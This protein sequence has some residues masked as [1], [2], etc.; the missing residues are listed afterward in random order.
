MLRN[1][2]RHA[3]FIATDPKDFFDT[4][5]N[6]L[7]MAMLGLCNNRPNGLGGSPI[8]DS[9]SRRYSNLKLIKVYALGVI[10]NV[11]T[12]QIIRS[13]KYLPTQQKS[14]IFSFIDL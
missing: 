7:R 13:D 1:H 11:L 12:P 4:E 10:F 5:K 3:L 9:A 8:L 14:Y 6:N 2:C